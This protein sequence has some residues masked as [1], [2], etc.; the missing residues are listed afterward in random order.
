M[1][2]EL[3]LV[4]SQL[5]QEKYK[6]NQLLEALLVQQNFMKEMEFKLEKLDWKQRNESQRDLAREQALQTLNMEL[7]T[8]KHEKV[9]LE[10]KY[11]TEKSHSQ[12]LKD[13]I[14][15]FRE[16]QANLDEV[17][18]DKQEALVKCERVLWDN[19]NLKIQ[20]ANV[21]YELK[22]W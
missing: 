6:S 5:A 12:K 16:N 15:R 11:Q 3:R 8:L 17:T 13:E 21:E 14:L 18:R 1:S 10:N 4:T 7:N 9:E 22:L 2:T 19:E 20:L